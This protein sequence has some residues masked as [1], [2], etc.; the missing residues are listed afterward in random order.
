MPLPQVQPN[1]R[2][3]LDREHAEYYGCLRYVSLRL[4]QSGVTR[5]LIASEVGELL[6]ACTSRSYIGIYLPIWVFFA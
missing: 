3:F 5:L 2:P 4:E 6:V 1:R